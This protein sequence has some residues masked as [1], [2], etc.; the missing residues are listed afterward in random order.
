[1]TKGRRRIMLE[2]GTEEL[3]KKRRTKAAETEEVED[4]VVEDDDV[5]QC[6]AMM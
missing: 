6:G 5:V 4:A 3:W 1:L 2:V